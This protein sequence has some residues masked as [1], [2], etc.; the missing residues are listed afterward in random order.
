MLSAAEL[1]GMQATSE[2]ALPAEC[3]ITRRPNTPAEV[4]PLTG[5]LVDPDAV[6]V[7]DGPC[8]LRSM[9]TQGATGQVGA[10][11][12][13]MG[14]YILTVPH[15][16][17]DVQVNDY[18]TITAGTDDSHIGRSYQVLDVYRSEWGIDRR[19]LV[20]DLQVVRPDGS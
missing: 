2:D 3:E 4:D 17:D 6:D 13:A 7:W 18:V 5:L 10:L 9:N 1:A 8:R 11:H 20:E 14:R 16:C 12:E 19:F 15:T